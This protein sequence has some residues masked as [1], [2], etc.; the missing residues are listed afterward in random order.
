[1]FL[2]M[3]KKLLAKIVIVPGRENKLRLSTKTKLSS[4]TTLLHF[5]SMESAL[6]ACIVGKPALVT[7]SKHSLLV[8][9]IFPGAAQEGFS[10][11][12]KPARSQP[13]LRLSYGSV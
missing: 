9:A 2:R 1:M 11:T 5:S 13:R 8:L 6:S 3:K 7:K 12:L 4:G 10:I